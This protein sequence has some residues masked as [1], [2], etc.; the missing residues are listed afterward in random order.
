MQEGAMWIAPNFDG[1]LP[2][3]K[4]VPNWVLARAVVRDGKITKPPYQPNGEPASHSNQATWNT[5]AAVKQ[6]YERGGYIGIVFVLDGKPHFG[7]HYLHGF[8]WDH[9]FENDRLDPVVYAE[10]KK[11]SI[12]RTE[13]SIS[14]TGVRG[15]F[16][17]EEPLPSTRTKIAG[18]S[19]ELYS[20]LRYMTTT[21]WGKGVLA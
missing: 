15:L 19:V 2:E 3:L 4:A 16:L 8:D 6:A 21:G 11:L 7:G 17:H 20:T 10:L 12:P 13:V 5:F 18:R 1:I 14:G 9:C